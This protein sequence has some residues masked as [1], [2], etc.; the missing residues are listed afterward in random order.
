MD[1]S[2][3]KMI[4]QTQVGVNGH[5]KFE[6]VPVGDFIIIPNVDGFKAAE[7]APIEVQVTQANQTITNADCTLIEA[8][9]SEI[10]QESTILPGDAFEDGVV[11]TKDIAAIAKYLMGKNPGNSNK[12]NA[13]ANNDGAINVADI[14]FIIGKK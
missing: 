4:A 12:N 10:F 11:D 5:Y 3:S 13:D 9:E 14:V 7:S 8:C 1:K 6:N 2:T